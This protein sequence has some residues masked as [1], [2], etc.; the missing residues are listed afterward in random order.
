[1][2]KII[3]IVVVLPI[4][5]WLFIKLIRSPKYDKWCKDLASGKLDTDVAPKDTMKNISKAEGDLGKQVETNIKEAEK[6][7]KETGGIKDFL[8]KRGVVDDAKE[9][10]EGS[11]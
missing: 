11:E 3:F 1:M 8:G 4:L 6:L 7:A 10:K 9:T 2:Y 5:I